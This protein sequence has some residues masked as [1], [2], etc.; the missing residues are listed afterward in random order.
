M[1]RRLPRRSPMP[2]SCTCICPRCRWGL[3]EGVPNV[4]PAALAKLQHQQTAA[5]EELSSCLG[6]LREAVE[7]AWRLPPTACSTCWS[8]RRRAPLLMKRAVFAVLPLRLLGG[9]V[10][11]VHSMHAA[12]LEVKAAVLRGLQEIVGAGKSAA[13]HS[14][15]RWQWPWLACSR[16]GGAVNQHFCSSP[17]HPPP[18]REPPR[19]CQRRRYL[20]RWRWRHRAA[21]GAAR[22]GC[23]AHR[24]RLPVSLGSVSRGG[25]AAGGGARGGAARGDARVLAPCWP[26]CACVNPH[27]GRHV[28]ASYTRAQPH[29]ILTRPSVS[30]VCTVCLGAT[31]R[32]LRPSG[33]PPQLLQIVLLAVA[34]QEHV[35]HHAARVHHQPLGVGLGGV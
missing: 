27:A 11:E 8:A 28:H 32:T 17:P 3:L 30:S 19:S 4:R 2:R 21:S 13:L 20:R 1:A 9:M 34:F 25:R 5:L 31:R 18:P 12:E 23:A 14:R 26:P 29:H 24:A 33:P 10:D 15:G 7:G 35:R 22:A 6:R 16:C